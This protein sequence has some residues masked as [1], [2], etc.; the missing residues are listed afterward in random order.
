MALAALIAVSGKVDDG[1]GSAS[2]IEV[3]ERLGQPSTYRIR[4]EIAADAGDY[5]MLTDSRLDAGSVLSVLVQGSGTKECLVKGPVGSQRIHFEHGDA[6]SYVEIRGSDSAIA[7]D[8]EAKSALWSDVT[9]SDAVN[10]IVGTYG[11]VP[12][13]DSTQAGH[14]ENKHVLVQRESDLS[15]VRKLARR[16]GF[17]FWVTSDA[18]GIE[19]AHFKKPPLGG[20]SAAK[21]AINRV[22]PAFT[23]LDLRW[24]VERPTS[25]EG[26]QLDLNALSDIDGGARESGLDKLGSSDLATITG[27][28][29]SI[30]LAPP[31][32]DAGDLQGRAA[33]ALVESNFFIRA[34]GET[35]L[36]ITGAPIRAHTVIEL[37]GAGSR[38]SGKYFVGGVRHTISP[39]SHLMEVELLRNGWGS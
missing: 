8:R 14:Y 1:L 16:N 24:D 35:A 2:W 12:D 38:H 9:D 29:R 26:T 34:T 10:A 11:F 15:F 39:D 30:F 4:Y 18:L 21:L 27:D 28:T 22:P 19:T 37:D 25:V 33:G 32:D 3:H 23:F 17:L 31:A 36:S 20:Q 13:L 7:M 5:S 6:G